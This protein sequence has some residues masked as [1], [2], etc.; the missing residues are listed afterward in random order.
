MTDINDK[1]NCRCKPGAEHTFRLLI[2][3]EVK[4]AT[5]RI[6]FPCRYCGKKIAVLIRQD[7]IYRIDLE[8]PISAD[9]R[10]MTFGW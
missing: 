8:R 9:H 4:G 6:T 5:G 7:G 10:W 1:V 3:D 2:A